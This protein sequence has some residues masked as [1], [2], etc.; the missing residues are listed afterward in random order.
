MRASAVSAAD[1]SGPSA[2]APAS[3][4]PSPRTENARRLLEAAWS[5]GPLTASDLMALT[6][7]TRATVLG[8]CKDLERAGWLKQA[9]DSR[10]AGVTAK[11]RPA[12]RYSFNP[13]STHVVG[14]DA[15]QHT[16]TAVLA[17][18]RGA[19]VHRCRCSPDPEASGAVR[20]RKLEQLVEDLLA[21]AGLG[22]DDVSAVTLGVPAPVD[23][24]G[25][26][27]SDVLDNFWPRMNPDLVTVFAE[28]PWQTIADN[29]A[30]LAAVA[31]S[32]VGVNAGVR[33]YAT[34]LSG[35]RFG[36]GI[37][38]DGHL[39]RGRRGGVG[40]MRVLDL[41]TGVGHP[42]GMTYRARQ[43]VARAGADGRL[44]GSSLAALPSDGVRAEHVFAAAREGDALAASIVEELAQT[45]AQVAMLLSGLLDLDRI[46]VAGAV[47]A[48]AQPVLERAR[49][50]MG[51][52]STMSW[53]ELV[54]SD[55]GEDVVLRGAVESAVRLVRASAL[56]GSS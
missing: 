1:L 31:E 19:E 30:N 16:M 3:A 35:E 24:E 4:A 50:I 37:V 51:H 13:A 40:E 27:P 54:A 26:S 6:G 23:A 34:L 39:L 44:A 43:E 28:R 38:I 11:G 17:D 32:S 55:L 48:S 14:V 52:E 36:A 2:S 46:I 41:V 9:S 5:R 56:T 21:D 8:L 47:A 53:A 7:L 10:A 20:R 18:L 49:E 15:G 22:D 29:D 42:H 33:T 25:R 45:L 12:L